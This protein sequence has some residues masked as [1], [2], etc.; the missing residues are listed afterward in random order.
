MTYAGLG[1]KMNNS[2]KAMPR[3]QRVHCRT[4]RKI[5][6][7]ETETR[8][9]AQELQPG[10]LERRVVIFVEIIQTDNV[11]AI[12]QE[13]ASNVEAVESRRAGDQYCVIRHLAPKE[14]RPKPELRPV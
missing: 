2:R 8:F 3:K 4:I 13:P 11:L 1:R 6:V 7:H 5:R 14:A 10:P 9:R 12:G